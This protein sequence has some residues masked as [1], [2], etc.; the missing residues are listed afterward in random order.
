MT[1]ASRAI[2]K[3]DAETELRFPLSPSTTN[4]NT[5]RA[6]SCDGLFHDHSQAISDSVRN[7][8][9]PAQLTLISDMAK[10]LAKRLDCQPD[11]LFQDIAEAFTESLRQPASGATIDSLASLTAQWPASPSTYYNGVTTSLV[12]PR[13]Q[14]SPVRTTNM[15]VENRA[16]GR[17]FSFHS[18]DDAGSPIPLTAE[19]SSI[20]LRLDKVKSS[21]R[22]RTSIS[23]AIDR[24]D[25]HED[26]DDGVSSMLLPDDFHVPM[27]RT[28]LRSISH[29]EDSARS[30]NTAIKD[31]LDR[32]CSSP[33]ES[34]T[35]V[36]QSKARDSLK[37][38]ETN[39]LAIA[40]ARVAGFRDN[41]HSKV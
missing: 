19:T 28:T 16:H 33:E 18:G 20:E 15:D 32:S 9:R 11:D 37:S 30:V 10:R 27:D 2:L 3:A 21:L 36:G 14:A 4:A 40:A 38:I 34:P 23:P 7:N 6:V 5:L 13:E 25:F 31:N 24:S 17:S 12:G 29:R 8:L 26:R 1:N 22:R 39:S 35:Q 41:L